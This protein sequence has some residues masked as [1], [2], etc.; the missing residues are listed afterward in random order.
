MMEMYVTTIDAASPREKMK[1]SE[2]QKIAKMKNS[3]F[4]CFFTDLL[5]AFSKE[6]TKM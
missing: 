5:L 1:I 3:I 6:I 4:S 2:A